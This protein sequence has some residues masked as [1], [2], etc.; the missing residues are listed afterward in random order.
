MPQPM[1]QADEKEA[2]NPAY[3]LWRRSGRLLRGWIIGTLTKEVLGIVVGLESA[4]E[5]WK[6][7]EDHFAQ[8]SQER[9][10]HLLQEISII[11]KG[12]DPLHEYIR[13]FKTLCDELS[14][15]GKPVSDQKK[16]FWFLQGLRPNYDNFVTTMLKPLVPLYK[17][18]IPLLQS[19]EARVQRHVSST[20][21]VAFFGQRTF[22]NQNKR[23]FG[24]NHFSSKGKGFVQTKINK[25]RKK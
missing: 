6:A 1:V 25:S 21:Q 7:L 9:E 16:V 23:N 22:K 14:A 20:P 15:T 17:D 11:R 2:P 4:S 5:V 10:F 8:N 24:Q 12:D 13:R 3:A 19:H 18:L